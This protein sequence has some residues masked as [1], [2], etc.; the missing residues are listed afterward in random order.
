VKAGKIPEHYWPQVQ[1]QLAVT[2]ADLCHFFVYH[3]ETDA[4]YLV[5]V[6]PDVQYQGK[7]IS[8]VL[9]FWQKYVLTDTAP[10]L[11]DKDV[12]LIEDDGSIKSLCEKLLMD[13]DTMK[14]AMLDS[15]KAEIVKLAGH[16]K[17]RCGSVQISTVLRKG[18]FSYHKLTIV[19]DKVS[20]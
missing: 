1:Y 4:D 17:M 6:K 2:G 13:K 10:A 9:D 11:T 5:E 20:A 18:A 16:P 7:I 8:A 19:G 14:K 3:E 15:L 12:K